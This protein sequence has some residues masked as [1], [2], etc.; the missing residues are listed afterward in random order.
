MN[1][2][3]KYTPEQEATIRQTLR[4]MEK[5]KIVGVWVNACP[6]A[7]VQWSKKAHGDNPDAC[8]SLL[9]AATTNSEFNPVTDPDMKKI[10]PHS[11]QMINDIIKSGAVT[12]RIST[13]T[14]K[15]ATEQIIAYKNCQTLLRVIADVPSSSNPMDILYVVDKIYA[16]PDDE[17][18]VFSGGYNRV[19]EE[20]QTKFDALTE[21]QNK[22]L[23]DVASEILAVYKEICLISVKVEERNA[24][25]GTLMAC[26]QVVRQKSGRPN[27]AGDWTTHTIISALCAYDGQ[28]FAAQSDDLSSEAARFNAKYKVFTPQDLP[29]TEEE[30]AASVTTIGFGDDNVYGA[31]DDP[32]HAEEEQQEQTGGGA[33]QDV[34]QDSV[35]PTQPQ[36]ASPSD[37][38]FPPNGTYTAK[39][40]VFIEKVA[41]DHLP[42]P[43]GAHIR[44]NGTGT[45]MFPT[46]YRK[47]QQN[48][49]KPKRWAKLRKAHDIKGRWEIYVRTG[50]DV[51]VAES[52]L[53]PSSQL[54]NYPEPNKAVT[55]KC[56]NF[57]DKNWEGAHT[58]DEEGTEFVSDHPFGPIYLVP[59]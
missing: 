46:E 33:P 37:G 6:N 4:K 48:T 7:A 31:N 35:V 42:T 44:T 1:N 19:T 32:H 40:E 54:G 25:L 38:H 18:L 12:V 47:V 29:A 43:L 53:F 17:I 34:P 50:M 49:I 24:V 23:I 5:K 30:M 41:D 3:T 20:F 15:P 14:D 56:P 39:A 22:S 51:D 45:L 16:V 55:Y 57:C 27:F 9:N 52:V 10:L 28:S 11:K 36:A 8:A 2:T 58:M 13:N 26:Q 21:G 59:V